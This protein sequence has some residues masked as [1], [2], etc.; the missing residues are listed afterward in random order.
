VNAELTYVYCLVRSARRPVLRGVP[1]GV[2]GASNPRALD[3][4]GHLWA[5]V[6]TVPPREYNEAALASGL[7]NLDWVGRR[8]MAHEAV[9]EHFL[10]ARALLPMQLF[11]LF[12]SDERAV[13]HV[14]RDRRRL[15]RILARIEQ[16]LEWGLR[17][18]FDETAARAGVAEPDDASGSAYLAR[19][20]DLLDVARLR[21]TEA[22]A[23]ADR[24]Y[25]AMS[26][27]ASEARRRAATEQAAPGSRLLLDAAFL[28]PSRRSAAFRSALR[29]NARKL[30]SIGVVVSLT[31]PWPPYNF[32]VPGKGRAR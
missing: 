2:P 13:A 27:E 25:R 15:D 8:A 10:P 11:T 1:D 29:R 19:K 17:L 31:G 32:I 7:P 28:V 23:A 22:R 18:T 21:L 6:A 24:L 14:A 16:Q 26:R 9:V 3:A 20:R 12:T 30:G 4:G 5:I